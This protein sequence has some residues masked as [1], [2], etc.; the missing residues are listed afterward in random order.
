MGFVWFCWFWNCEVL[1][2]IDVFGVCWRVWMTSQG[3]VLCMLS[4]ISWNDFEVGNMVVFYF[5]F[6]PCWMFLT[7]YSNFISWYLY[8]EKL[9][10]FVKIM[11]K[12]HTFKAREV[13]KSLREFEILFVWLCKLGH[14]MLECICCFLVCCRERDLWGWK[15]WEKTKLFV[16][17]ICVCV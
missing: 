7:S 14:D 2:V 16:C 17:Y 6:V 3:G 5:C 10:L 9:G 1:F 12:C 8:A 15:F 11:G 13:M 4:N